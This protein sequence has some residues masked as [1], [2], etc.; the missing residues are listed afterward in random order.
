MSDRLIRAFDDL[1]AHME[2]P[3]SWDEIGVVRLESP[4]PRR[5][6]PLVLVAGLTAVLVVGLVAAALL[7]GEEAPTGSLGPGC[8]MPP[9]SEL[10][11]VS[12]VIME[13]NPRPALANTEVMLTVSDPSPGE[14]S[15]NGLDALWQCWDGN[16]WVDTH[17]LIRGWEGSRPQTVELGVEIAWEA[18]GLALPNT[19]PILV[20]DVPPGVY[21]ITDRVFVEGAAT[22]GFVLVEVVVE[23]EPGPEDTSGPVTT[24]PSVS[25]TVPEET[26]IPPTGPLFGDETGHVLLFDDGIDGVLALDPDAR[27]G[28]RSVIDGQREGDQPY[29]MH[30]VADT[31]VVGWGTVYG[32]DLVTGESRLLGNAT[33]FVPAAEPD[34]VWLIEW[35]GG[36]VG[37]GDPRVWQVDAQGRQITEPI[38]LGFDGMPTIGVP[39]GLALTTDVGI[40]LWYP[41]GGVSDEVLGSD[42]AVVAASNETHLAY[43]TTQ[44]CLEVEVL[45]FQSGERVTISHPDHR[46]Y[47]IEAQ[48]SPD[49]TLIALAVEDGVLVADVATGTADKIVLG[50]TPP[51][52]TNWSPD[53]RMLFIG[54]FSYDETKNSLRMYDVETGA[55][56]D[57]SVPFG[58]TLSFVVLTPDEAEPF[59]RDQDQPP[60]ACPPVFGY[61]SGR[62]GICGFRF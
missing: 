11:A 23:P 37:L 26:A 29:R 27:I 31:L 34:R 54:E 53:G 58:G 9:Q 52:L 28:S 62:E 33:I 19:H 49:G 14:G 55:T 2:T 6:S 57:A 42:Y 46:F 59:L 51:R 39:G 56:T 45:E 17:Q 47:F 12:P 21:R 48:F 38:S 32:T 50:G 61:P 1:L 16:G 41:E 5:R 18:V 36:S 60:S 44:E 3:P 13:V 4:E 25:T 24:T 35:P 30:R 7:G 10:D 43:C 22:S 40:R 20:P 15:N 8:F